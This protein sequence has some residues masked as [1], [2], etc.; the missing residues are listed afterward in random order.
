MRESG[1]LNISL[2]HPFLNKNRKPVEGVNWGG[3]QN[4]SFYD[5][6]R[7]NQ[8][9]IGIEKFR[10]A[11]NDLVII[12]D[13]F[14]VKAITKVLEEPRPL[15]ENTDYYVLFEK[16]NVHFED[17]VIYAKAEWYELN[18]ADFFQCKIQRGAGRV[19][20]PETR[21]RILELWNNRNSQS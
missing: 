1:C 8:I 18:K 12:T 7:D 2:K 17:W 3:R 21:A 16:Y 10:Y 5:F 9:V 6:A 19:N 14:T 4:P 15:V 20:H 13:G 11:V